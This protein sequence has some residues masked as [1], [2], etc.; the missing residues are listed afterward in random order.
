MMS[1]LDTDSSQE[2]RYVTPRWV[3][4]F[5]VV[6]LIIVLLLALGMFE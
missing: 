3:K 5:A 6:T 1:Q 4:V 2:S